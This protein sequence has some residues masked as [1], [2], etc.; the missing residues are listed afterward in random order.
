MKFQ[1]KRL[2]NELA[3]EFLQRLSEQVGRHWSA[4]YSDV[5]RRVVFSD[6][7]LII[8]QVIFLLTHGLIDGSR[9][10]EGIHMKMCALYRQ[11]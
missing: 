6:K 7:Q 4:E 2:Q 11:E 1:T 10:L 5:A 3:E 8:R 9:H